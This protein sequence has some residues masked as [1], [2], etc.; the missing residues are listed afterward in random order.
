[1]ATVYL[2]HSASTGNSFNLELLEWLH[3]KTGM[4]AKG[5][6]FVT[7]RKVTPAVKEYLE[8]CSVKSTPV[9]EIKDTG[10]MDKFATEVEQG[11]LARFSVGKT[12]IQSALFTVLN[13]PL[14]KASK[15]SGVVFGSAEVDEQ[16]ALDDGD[17][18]VKVFLMSTLNNNDDDEDEEDEVSRID[19]V[20]RAS[21]G[22]LTQAPA[23]SGSNGGRRSQ[24]PNG[25][26]THHDFM[27][28]SEVTTQSSGVPDMA[29]MFEGDDALT[30]FW[31]NQE[32][33]PM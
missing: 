2:A 9:L 8:S 27:T 19:R 15:R 31:E 30:R 23:D 33:T 22:R 29:S 7:V 32:E 24:P 20:K 18:E 16:S 10:L 26:M 21:A 12:A 17:D 11:D 3:S 13:P 5:G 1:M 25:S 6:V 14:G 4:F 28:N